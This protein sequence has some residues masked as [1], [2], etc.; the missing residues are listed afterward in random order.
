MDQIA[1]Q[2]PRAGAAALRATARFAAALA[3]VLAASLAPAAGRAAAAQPFRVG[4]VLS[5]GL[6][7]DDFWYGGLER[8]VRDIGVEGRLLVPGPREGYLP[9]FRSL[10]REGF[11]LVIA[12]SR[13]PIPAMEIA[14]TQYPRTRFAV[15]DV[16]ALPARSPSNLWGVGFAEE[17]V[18][19]LAGYL[20]GRMEQRMPGR[21]VVGSVGGLAVPPV[22][23]FIAGYQAGARR[24]DPGIVTLSDYSNSFVDQGKC[25][26]VAQ[27]Q[28]AKGAGV[29][30]DVAG[31]C[32]L[33]VLDAAK[34]EGV[35]AIGVDFDES[36]RGPHVLTSALKDGRS[37]VFEVIH[38]AM[39]GRFP[40]GHVTLLGLSTGAVGLGR[41]SR[42]VPR[43]LV[44]QVRRVRRRIVAGTIGAIP[45]TIR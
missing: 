38:A 2:P 34:R 26:T 4:L 21:D 11:D 10:A 3:A 42:A 39:A 12:A 41:F 20:A 14:A 17:E 31:L 30:F 23:R 15:L 19:F 8:A 18:G 37:A 13:D 24:A 28:I 36:R 22:D 40:G 5:P 43:S 16:H 9:S 25:R 45:T 44:R 6:A 27:G 35:W 1:A 32:G 7:R 33:G 29:V